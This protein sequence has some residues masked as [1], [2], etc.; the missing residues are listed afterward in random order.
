MLTLASKVNILWCIVD[1][2]TFKFSSFKVKFIV[3]G[4]TSK[5]LVLKIN[6]SCL[7][8]FRTARLF[9]CRLLNDISIRFHKIDQEVW[10]SNSIRL[11]RKI[12]LI[13]FFI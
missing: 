3:T 8:V 10:S 1:I 4:K 13:T 9:C 2:V 5:E 7:L 6:I 12:T 11:K